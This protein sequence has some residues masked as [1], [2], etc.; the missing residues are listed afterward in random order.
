MTRKRPIVKLN[1]GNGLTF[2]TRKRFNV[3]ILHGFCAFFMGYAL[4]FSVK[5]FEGVYLIGFFGDTMCLLFGQ[6]L[7]VIITVC[8]TIVNKCI[9]LRY[10]SNKYCRNINMFAKISIKR[11]ILL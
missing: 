9:V 11:S 2:Y 5:L 6:R 7:L 10:H 8:K 3:R 4:F 1:V